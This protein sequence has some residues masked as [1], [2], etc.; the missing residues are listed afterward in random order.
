MG[1]D[2]TDWIGW[3]GMQMAV[4]A[5]KKSFS[6][7]PW[8]HIYGMTCELYYN[9]LNNNEM[10]ICNDKDT[11]IKDCRVIRPTNLYLVPRV[12]DAIKN[13]IEFLNKPIIKNKAIGYI[14]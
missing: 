13:K 4:K 14:R 1:W 10:A 7:L 3:D 11:F 12:L 9:V 5:E 2:G 8:A 6:I